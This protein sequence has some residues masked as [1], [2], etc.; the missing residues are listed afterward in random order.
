MTPADLAWDT[1][2]TPRS[3]RYD[4]VYHARAGATEQARHV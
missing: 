2:G 4:D 3:L 1:D